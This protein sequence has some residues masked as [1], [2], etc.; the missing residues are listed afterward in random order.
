MISLITKMMR[1]RK[2]KRLILTSLMSGSSMLAKKIK[3]RRLKSTCLKMR[4]LPLRRM[5]GIAFYGQLVTE[6]KK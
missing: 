4:L 6:M 3:C 2:N 1:M 5:D